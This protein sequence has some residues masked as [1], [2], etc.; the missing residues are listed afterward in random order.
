MAIKII[1][2]NKFR[3][4]SRKLNHNIKERIEKQIRKTL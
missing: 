4:I 2:S 3:N 1:E